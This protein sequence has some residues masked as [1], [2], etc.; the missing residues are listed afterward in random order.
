MRKAEGLTTEDGSTAGASALSRIPVGAKVVVLG[1]YEKALGPRLEAKLGLGAGLVRHYSDAAQDEHTLFDRLQDANVVVVIRER[2]PLSGSL[3]QRLQ[4]LNLIVTTGSNTSVIDLDAGVPVSATR[5]MASAA[6]ELTWALI[7]SS[8]RNIVQESRNLHEGRWQQA[9]GLGL[10][11]KQLGILGLGRI[12]GRVAA[13]ARAFGMDV[14]A[15]SRHLTAEGARLHG[16]ELVTK[17]EL[18]ASSDIVSLHLRLG[19]SSKHIIDDDALSLMK[20]TSILVNTARAG[21][22]DEAAVLRALSGG[23]LAGFAQDVF[24]E[25]PLPR[26]S[27]L[28]DAPNTLLTPH[29]GYVTDLNMDVFA[30]DIDENIRDFYAKGSLRRLN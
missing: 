10:E 15:W 5:S 6:A 30:A 29:L 25:E 27:R 17:D 13:V 20:P 8:A 14:V 7:L 4:D 22:V 2:T 9:V 26:D 11:G 3:I 23:T 24:Y 28:L 19:E 16:A 18:L 1:D 12:G 21:L